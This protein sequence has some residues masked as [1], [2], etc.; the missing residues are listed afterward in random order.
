MLRMR[1]VPTALFVLCCA[2]CVAHARAV[3]L[4]LQHPRV[5]MEAATPGPQAGDA[6]WPCQDAS[7]AG[8]PFCDPSLSPEERARDLVSRLTLEEKIP[9]LGSTAPGVP[10]LSVPPYIY[11]NEALHGVGK[12]PGVHFRGQTPFAVSFPQV[13][14]LAAAFNMSMVHAVA[15][16]IATEARAFYSAGNAGLTFWSPNINIVRD[17][18]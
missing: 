4:P 9:E 11:W 14:G 16:A 13:V 1:I 10:R 7:V 15:Q 8:L 3:R 5:A 18:R 12:S 17:P 6:S 2:V